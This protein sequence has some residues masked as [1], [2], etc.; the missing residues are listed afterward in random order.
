[1]YRVFGNRWCKRDGLQARKRTDE[2]DVRMYLL[3]TVR[4]FAGKIGF[5]G[6]VGHPDGVEFAQ[7]QL[8]RLVGSP[9]QK[10]VG[11]AQV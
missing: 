11:H 7:S 4:E 3:P 8:L 6:Y 5:F 2:P 1:M 10:P 9:F